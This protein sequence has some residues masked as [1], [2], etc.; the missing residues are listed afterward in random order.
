MSYPIRLLPLLAFFSNT[1][2][3]M[4]NDSGVCNQTEFLWYAQDH[5]GTQCF[6]NIVL[7]NQV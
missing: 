5:H 6:R 1:C 3:A 7:C 4:L 2:Y